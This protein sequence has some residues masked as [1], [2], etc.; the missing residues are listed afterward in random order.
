VLVRGLNPNCSMLVFSTMLA[1][2]VKP[3][4]GFGSTTR[5]YEMGGVR[6][7]AGRSPELRGWRW[8]WVD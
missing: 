5:N 7:T 8:W 1:P 4:L 6:K 3:I 2:V